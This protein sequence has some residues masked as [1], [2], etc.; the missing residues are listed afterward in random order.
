MY[1]YQTELP[2]LLT[3]EGVTTIINTL[4]DAKR[5]CIETGECPVYKITQPGSSWQSQAAV[6]F[7]VEMKYLKYTSKAGSRQYWTVALVN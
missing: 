7:L 4:R 3:K 5:Y 6:D 2:K 1:N